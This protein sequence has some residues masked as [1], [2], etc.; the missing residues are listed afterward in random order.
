MCSEL[1]VPISHYTYSDY[2]IMTIAENF[3]NPHAA[4]L[5]RIKHLQKEY[6]YV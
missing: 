4:N 3:G 2:K 6:W 1:G 5:I